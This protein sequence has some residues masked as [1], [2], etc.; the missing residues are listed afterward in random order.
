[1]KTIVVPVDFSDESMAGLEMA[2]L[3]AGKTGSAIQM[4]HV[5]TGLSNIARGTLG[6]EYDLA[7]A[8]FNEIIEKYKG[9]NNDLDLSFIIKEGKVYKEIKNQAEAY[10]NSMIILST[11]GNSGIEEFFIGSNAYKIAS[12]A[13][14]PVISIRSL[15][16]TRNVRTIVL[17]LDMTKETREKVPFTAELA[18]LFNAKIY[19]L[20]LR[21]SNHMNIEKKLEAYARQVGDYLEK[22]EIP[23]KTD[24]LSGSNFTDITLEY[25]LAEDADL[26][27][28]M[29][30][31][32]ESISNFLLGNYAHQM[33]NK[34][35]VPV[36]LFPTY[37]I[38]IINE[39]LRTQGV[40]VY[41]M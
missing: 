4:V 9:K 19:L 27:S 36:L 12:S 34:S 17:P 30:E 2:I 37:N 33:I 31:Q 8:R 18:K 20:T 26:I 11:H 13:S 14:R 21:S 7:K 25:A 16:E 10:E 38:T 35:P 32:E 39:S 24:H 41:E 29:T 1:M 15:S 5:I 6:K 40:Y 3:I 23:F 28:V 22:H